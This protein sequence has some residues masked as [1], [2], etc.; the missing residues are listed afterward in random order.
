MRELL[1]L[2]GPSGAGK[3]TSA[4]WLAEHKDFFVVSST[5]YVTRLKE[6]ILH[7]QGVLYTNN[8]MR[9]CISLLWPGGFNGF[10]AQNMS[11]VPYDR[12]AWDACVNIHNLGLVL[13]CFDKACFLS[14]D[15]PM[16]VRIKRVAERKIYN[17]LSLDDVSRIV[18]LIDQYERSLGLGDLML[19]SDWN[20]NTYESSL[21]LC[22]DTFFRQCNPSSIDIKKQKIENPFPPLSRENFN[23]GAFEK[24]LEKSGIAG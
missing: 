15:A 21:D 10:M 13:D 18:E 5:T 2:I 19:L 14:L 1:C 12:I 3:S 24:Y 7:S 11:A 22:M 9:A 20:V 16:Q 17:G 23:T 8:D 4:K 6:D